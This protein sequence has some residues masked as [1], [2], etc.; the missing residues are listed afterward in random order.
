V[1]DLE[2]IANL[3][4]EQIRTNYRVSLL[5]LFFL[6]SIRSEINGNEPLA[7]HESLRAARFT[8]AYFAINKSRHYCDVILAHSR[9]ACA[10][11]LSSYNLW[12]FV[13]LCA[14]SW[15]FC[16][17]RSPFS[18]LATVSS[19]CLSIYLFAILFAVINQCL[20]DLRREIS[21]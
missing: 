9:R 11:I 20:T 12:T 10:M 4:A 2:N 18:I 1:S 17:L 15:N 6:A 3:L 8:L 19:V 21:I 13:L 16:N 14:P 7:R 5:S